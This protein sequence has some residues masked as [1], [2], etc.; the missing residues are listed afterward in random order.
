M[1]LNDFTPVSDKKFYIVMS[2]EFKAQTAFDVPT[3]IEDLDLRLN[4]ASKTPVSIVK[5]LEETKDCTGEYVLIEQV[6]GKIA[7]FTFNLEVSPKIAAGFKALALSA[8]AAPTGSPT[9]EIQTILNDGDGGGFKIGFDF[10]G[11][12]DTTGIIAFDADAA[13]VKAELANLRAIKKPENIT[14]SGASLAAGFDVEFIGDLAKANLPLL[15]IVDDTTTNG[16]AAV[17]ADTNGA[18]KLHLFARMTGEQPKKFSFVTGFDAPGQTARFF[19][20][21]VIDTFKLSGTRRGKLTLEVT[22]YAS[23]DYEEIP[24]YT[25]PVCVTVYPTYARDCRVAVD[26]VFVTN[27]LYQFTENYSNAIDTSEFAFRFDDV[28]IDELEITDRTSSLDLQF[29]GSPADDLFQSADDLDF[30]AIDLLVGNPGNRYATIAPN[31]QLK[32]TDEQIVFIGGRR[33]SAFNITARPSPDDVGTVDRSEYIGAE[34][35]TF[36]AA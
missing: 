10:E 2:S 16:T 22:G 13:T 24:N 35:F 3:D 30:A 12:S 21:A 17:T 8:A 34:T 33:K 23:A 9:N 7:K 15:T 11:L 31:A 4:L 1:A 28:N 29:L 19:R 6:S 36:L 27:G 26:D 14:V 5:T 25:P 20:N 18:N 32:L